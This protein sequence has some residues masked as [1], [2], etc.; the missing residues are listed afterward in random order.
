MNIP[1]SGAVSIGFN[2]TYLT[3]FLK[4]SGASDVKLELKDAQSA[5]QFRPAD[6]EEYKYRYVVMPMRI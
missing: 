3:D 6:G 5:G 2:A 4:A 1:I